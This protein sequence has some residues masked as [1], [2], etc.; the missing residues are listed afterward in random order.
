MSG[1]RFFHGLTFRNRT[2]ID[3]SG[4]IRPP[5]SELMTREVVIPINYADGTAEVATNFKFPTTAVFL[6]AYVNIR[7]AEAT[8]TTK[9]FKVGTATAD[10]GTPNLFLD[11][12]IASAT[13]LVDYTNT[14][15]V[16][17]T[18]GSSP[19]TYTSPYG[20]YLTITGG[21]TTHINVTRGTTTTSDLFT[22]TPGTVYLSAGDSVNVTYSSVPTVTA[23]Q[24]DPG[25]IIAS[26]GGKR[27]SWTPASND[28]ANFDGDLIVRYFVLGDLTQ[29][30]TS[31]EQP[32]QGV[33]N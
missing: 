30:Q 21:T 23:F 6:D 22:T 27:I 13:G 8:G 26:V 4:N 2:Y 1:S 19:A 18:L 31:G 5:R 24:S 29:Y 9:T 14:N 15:G 11:G 32:E 10:S 28:W 17:I 33:G 16:A 7:T 20:A 25:P 12:V 3:S